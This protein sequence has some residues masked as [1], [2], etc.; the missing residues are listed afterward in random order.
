MSHY[1]TLGIPKT[2]SPEEIKQAYRKAASKNH[3]DKGGDTVK[4]QQVE[5]AYRILSD[6]QKRS[7]Y[8]NPPQQMGS[9]HFHFDFGGGNLHDI[10]SQFGFGP[11]SP[12]GRPPQ[13][14]KNSDLRTSINLGL[15]ETLVDTL[16]VLSIKNANNDRQNVDIRIPRGITSG[17]TIKYPGL[18]D[19]MFP[20]LPNGDLLVTV[21]VLQ[22]P[23][24][25][26]NGLD[27]TTN[28]T[29]DCFQAILGSEQTVVGLDGK[30]FLI[31]TPAGC[32]PNLKLKISGEGLWGFQNDI[33][34]HLFVKVNITIPT[35]LTED[36]KNLIQAITNQR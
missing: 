15:Q 20:N 6:P 9:N 14:R 11:G 32:Q 24:Y 34:G 12:F 21:N 13:P 7:E 31:K 28:L 35:D 3:P 5:E 25:Q 10:F 22:H 4:F 17:T 18:G 33:K 19:F 2:S 8:D 27:L 1:E 23:S 26:V 36:Q 16:K 29:I 30:T